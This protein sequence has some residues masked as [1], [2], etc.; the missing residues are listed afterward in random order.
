MY[1]KLGIRSAL[2]LRATGGGN[3]LQPNNERRARAVATGIDSPAPREF[4]RPERGMRLVERCRL[5]LG[6][7]ALSAIMTSATLRCLAQCV[8]E[9]RDLMGRKFWG[10]L[11]LFASIVAG[12]GVATAADLAVKAPAPPPPPPPVILSDWAGFYLGVHG[13]YG[14]ANEKFDFNSFANSTLTGGLGGIHAGYSWQFGNVVAGVEVDW[15][16]AGLKKS[17]PVI[18]AGVGDTLRI[19]SDTL[20]S[21]RAR[22]GYVVIP[23]LL[24]YGTAGGSWGHNRFNVAALGTTDDIANQFGWVAGGG[25]EYKVWGPLIA[26]IEYLHYDFEKKTLPNIGDNVKESVDTVRGGLSYKF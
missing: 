5:L 10:G 7:V 8:S 4:V 20:A 13:G 15:D 25:L 17:I 1:A 23:S 6:M 24:A 12:A 18:V 9:W 22:L 21:A 16:G 11:G 3:S 14:S 19:E 26:R 2:H